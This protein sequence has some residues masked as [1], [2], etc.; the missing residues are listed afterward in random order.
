M[1]FRNHRHS[2]VVRSTVRVELVPL[3]GLSQGQIEDE[4]KD[5]DDWGLSRVG[6]SS[7]LIS[8]LSTLS[9]VCTSDVVPQDV[10]NL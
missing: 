9:I 10:V 6:T 8:A 5:L 1:K 7:R 4:L 3:I 2:D